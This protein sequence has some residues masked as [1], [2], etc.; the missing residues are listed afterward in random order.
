MFFNCVLQNIQKLTKV[1]TS[2]TDKAVT[3]SL[4]SKAERSIE[5]VAVL[6]VKK[7]TSVNLSEQIKIK[8]TRL[9][10]VAPKGQ[11]HMKVSNLKRPSNMFIF[12]PKIM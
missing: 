12:I 8:L 2:T 10:L 11:H 6:A 3:I 9:S 1:V 7:I 5:E 4:T